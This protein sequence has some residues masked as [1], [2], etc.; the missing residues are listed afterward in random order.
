MLQVCFFPVFLVFL[1]E[2]S[3]VLKKTSSMPILPLMI[4][5]SL[6]I[7]SLKNDEPVREEDMKKESVFLWFQRVYNQNKILFSC[8][9]VSQLYS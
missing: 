3:Y 9:K 6:W 7:Y 5:Y 8:I 4:V 2:M 1:S